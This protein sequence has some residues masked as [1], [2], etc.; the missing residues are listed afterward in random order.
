[1]FSEPFVKIAYSDYNQYYPTKDK[2]GSRL[3]VPG[4]Y[5]ILVDS[6]G[7]MDIVCFGFPEKEMENIDW[8]FCF[9]RCIF[10]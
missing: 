1:M 7:I 3:V 2:I 9:S 6:L 5:Y 8:C 10:G 4:H